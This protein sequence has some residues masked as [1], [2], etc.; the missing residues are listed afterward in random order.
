LTEERARVAP[1]VEFVWFAGLNI[2]HSLTPL[3]PDAAKS[4]RTAAGESCRCRGRSP[5]SR[6]C[7]SAP[8]R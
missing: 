1:G 7:L 5:A 2:G 3:R 8:V 4:R 6:A